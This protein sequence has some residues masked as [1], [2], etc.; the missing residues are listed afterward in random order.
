MNHSGEFWGDVKNFIRLLNNLIPGLGAHLPTEAEWEYA[1]RAGTT[2][3]Y[4]CAEAALYP[5][6]CSCLV[7][8]GWWASG[9]IC[10]NGDPLDTYGSTACDPNYDS[11]CAHLVGTKLPNAFGI[12]DMIGNVREHVEDCYHD[13]YANAPIDGSAWTT[14]CQYPGV[15]RGSVFRQMGSLGSAQYMRMA[16][17]SVVSS[18]EAFSGNWYSDVGFR[19]VR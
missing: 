14:D 17:R 9:N 3:A 13:S 15:I 1:E 4:Y 2:A 16:F 6:L 12:F 10:G 19:C 8:Y 18:D 11:A 5:D 7:P